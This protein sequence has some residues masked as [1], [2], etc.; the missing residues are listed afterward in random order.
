M[1]GPEYTLV[2]LPLVRQLESMG[3]T[4]LAG[5]RPG[6]VVPTDPEAS[7]RRSFTEVVLEERLRRKLREINSGPDGRPWLDDARVSRAVAAI[8]RIGASGLLEA[9]QRATELLLSGVAVDGLPGWDGGRDQRVHFVDWEHWDRNDFVVVSQFRVDEPGTQGAKY[10]VPDLVLFVN[11]IPLVVIEC[12]KPYAEGSIAEAVKQILRYANRRGASVPEGNEKLFHTVQLTVATCSD[13]ARLGT[14]TSGPEHY[15]TWRD[16]Y[17]LTRDELAARLGKPAE[18]VT[19]QEVLAAGVL[20]PER[21][22]DIVHNFTLFMTEDG[23]T[24]KVAPRYQQYRAVCKAVE[25]LRTGKTRAQDGYADRRGGIVWHTQGSGKSLTMVFL[26][27]KMRATPDLRAFKVVVVTD[28]TD[29]QDQLARTAQL[30]GETVE[31]AKRIK[32]VKK[33][34]A[35]RG[36][37]IVFAMIQKQQDVEARKAGDDVLS[38]KQAPPL[39]VLNTDEEILILV[40]EAHRS[41]TSALHANLNVALPNAAKIGFTGTP[42]IMGQKKRTTQ[43]FGDF[44]DTYRLPEAEADGAIVPIFYEGRTTRGAVRDGRDLDEVFEDMFRE[45]SAEEREALQRRYATKGNVLEA[46][47]LIAAKARDMLR[48]YVRT[49]L[50][51]RFKAQVV[52]HSRL[53]TL[54]YREAFLAARDELVAQ[55]EALPGAAADPDTLDRRTAFLARA[56]AHLDLLRAIDFVPVIS[57][58]SANDEER[59]RPWTGEEAHRTA[60]AAFKKP[61]PEQLAPGERPVAFLIVKSM[62]LTGFDAPVEQV[63]YLDRAM[64]E[65]ELLQTVA[66]VNRTAPGKRVGLVVD[67]YGVANHLREALAAYATED[68]AGALNDLREEIAKLRP[69]RDRLRLLFTER[70]VTPGRDPAAREACVQLLA[71]EELRDRFEVALKAFLTTVDTVLPRPEATEYLADA[72]LYAEIGVWARRRYREAGDFEP[73]LYGQKVRELID[74]HVASLGIDQ[75]I[76]PVSLTESDFK[77]KVDALPGAKARASEMAHA[78]RHHIECHLAEDPVRYRKLRERLEEI[79]KEYEEQWEQQALL[80]EELVDE[81]ARDSGQG[82]PELVSPLEQALYRLLAEETV[83]SG[84]IDEATARRLRDVIGKVDIVVREHVFKVDFWRNPVAQRL[85][86]DEIVALLVDEQVG[87]LDR[88]ESLADELFEVVKA[89]RGRLSER[90]R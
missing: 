17:P 1:G 87:E 31:V 6:A 58:G 39:G 11:G 84:V 50:P 38:H 22:L 10:V 82:E 80:L 78:I 62:L 83:T 73:A 43:I 32:Q 29:L 51:N 72:K 81:L 18:A 70:G 33:L 60:I 13:R 66:R 68:I 76:P 37:G 59:Y 27:R 57:P 14:I 7:G 41:H 65:A 12:K 56:R 21:L 9:N 55:I 85:C 36:P 3:W 64:R 86:R 79:L 53:A 15:A 5:A 44:L 69:R 45:L 49:V 20:H 47:E 8:T 67:Y 26:V 54:R 24:V 74:R 48:H 28:R 88:V 71:D 30:T 52:A 35:R 16:P 90:D 4:H 63:L 2:E 61:F 89:N 46:P 34:L 40:D 77:A 42:I 75:T 23:R 19:A 25:R